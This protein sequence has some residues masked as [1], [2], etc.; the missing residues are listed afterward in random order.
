MSLPVAEHRYDAVFQ[1]PVGTLGIR[2]QGHQIKQLTWLSSKV[3][4][5][6]RES[7]LLRTIQKVLHDYFTA[8]RDFPS[9][10]L[11]PDGTEFQARV[12]DALRKIPSGEVITYGQLARHLNTSSRAIGQACRANPIAVLIPCHR[13]VAVNGPGG[14]MGKAEKTD[15]K[16][17]LLAH[18]DHG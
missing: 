8:A 7:R 14:Y 17:W 10:P 2:L 15:I 18:E 1:A 13:V 5:G 9:L 16:Q 4:I 11:A 6:H 12:W 3:T